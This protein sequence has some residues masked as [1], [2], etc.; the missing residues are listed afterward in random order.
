MIASDSGPGGTGGPPGP[1]G[2]RLPRVAGR[3][4]RR[5]WPRAFDRPAGDDEGGRDAGVGAALGHQGQHFALARGQR[6]Q[7]LGVAA[8]AEELADHLGV[9]GG[10]AGGDP[11]QGVDELGD[12]GD[13]VL[14]Q[15]ANPAAP[16]SSS[17]AAYLVSMYWRT[18]ARRSRDAG[19]G[20]RWRCAAPRR[21]GSVACGC[22][23]PRR[24]D[25]ARRRRR[26]ARSRRPRRRRPGGRGRRGAGSAPRASGRRPRRSRPAWAACSHAWSGSSTVTRRPAGRLAISMRPST[27]LTRCASPDRP[28]PAGPPRRRHRR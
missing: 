17:R 22:P 7:L 14:E 20:A 12:V 18:P 19:G 16:P 26:A 3:A 27:V 2:C 4:C 6:G 13:P 24:R 25:G 23:R 28:L 9:E 21:C 5:C 11:G 1:G 8:G 15:V 10:A